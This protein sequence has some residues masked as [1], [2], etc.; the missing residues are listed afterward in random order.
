MQ[1]LSF[2]G[3][4]PSLPIYLPAD[5]AVVPFGDPLSD[6]T[7]T[8]STT[9]VINA[10]GYNNPLVNDLVS[11]SA[12]AG[13]AVAAG[14]TAGALYYVN[15]IVSTALATF[16]ISTVKGGANVATTNTGSGV[17][18]LHL[19]NMQKY[20]TTSPFKSGSTAVALNISA[21]AA[22][23]KGAPDSNVSGQSGN[24]TGPGVYAVIATVASGTGAMVQLN[25]DWLQVTGTGTI[26]LLQN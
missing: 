9:A 17:Q 8:S 13:G 20:G 15:A 5:I 23:L 11:F 7:I 4:N 24:P 12:A 26:I 19:L 16:S 10:P 1:I 18:T 14:I 25:Y 21:A 3:A 6:V 2:V 22:T